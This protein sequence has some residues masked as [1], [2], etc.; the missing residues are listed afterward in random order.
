MVIGSAFR[1]DLDSE[2]RGHL[3]RVIAVDYDGGRP[4][5]DDRPCARPQSIGKFSGCWRRVGR[6]DYKFLFP[7]V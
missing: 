2:K 6:P 5:V 3:E 1:F 4:A 7:R